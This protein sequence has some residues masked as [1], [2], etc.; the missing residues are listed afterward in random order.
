MKA[1]AKDANV[2]SGRRFTGSVSEEEFKER[3]LYVSRDITV[4]DCGLQ[5]NVKLSVCDGYGVTGL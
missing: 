2:I 1:L 5:C 3:A 4:A